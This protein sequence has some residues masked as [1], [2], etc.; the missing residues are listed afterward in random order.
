MLLV[1]IALKNLRGNL[2]FTLFFILNLSIGLIG[3]TMLD[4][5]KSSF[6]S[7]VESSSKEMATADLKISARKV[8]APGK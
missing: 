5:F 3:Y 4:G 6:K 1:K 8:F 7:S 2:S